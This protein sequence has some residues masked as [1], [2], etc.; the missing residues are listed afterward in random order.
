[1]ERSSAAVGAIAIALFT[2]TVLLRR[3][4]RPGSFLGHDRLIDVLET[5]PLSRSASLHVVRAGVAY[6]VVGHTDGGIT[7]VSELPKD[8]VEHRMK[9]ACSPGTVS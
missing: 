7:L 1:M 6:Y 4:T 3:G 5:K 9:R 2:G 8:V